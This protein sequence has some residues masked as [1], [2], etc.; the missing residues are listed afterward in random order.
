[1]A[2]QGL[3]RLLESEEGDRLGADGREYLRRLTAAT[4]RAQTLLRV[5]GE[6]LRTGSPALPGPPASLGELAAEAAA[7]LMVLAPRP[8]VGYDFARAD[9]MVE[10]SAGVRQALSLL[11]RLVAQH[12][13]RDRPAELRVGGRATA[14]GLEVWVQDDGTVWPPGD[15]DR[16]F[17]PFAFR[18][19]SGEPNLQPFLARE[20]VEGLG[21]RLAVRSEAGQ[22]TTFTMTLP[23]CVAPCGPTG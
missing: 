19:P 14:E 17:A 4:Q 15:L 16:L 1:M 5:L 2:V 8:I 3:A 18:G 9:L 13:P 22:G 23:A 21:G 10:R 7:E 20:V 11:L 12:P 6:V